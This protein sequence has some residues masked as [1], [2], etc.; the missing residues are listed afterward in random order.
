MDTNLPDVRAGQQLSATWLNKLRD[1]YLASRRIVQG[2][3]VF[4][5][6]GPDGVV[7]TVI[8]ESD[9]WAKITY[10]GTGPIYSWLE[11]IPA[12]SGTWA[13]GPTHGHASADPAIGSEYADPAYEANNGTVPVNTIV[14]C[15]RDK[16]AGR[17]TFLY[18]DC[19]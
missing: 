13:D 8:R 6:T 1:L 18:S 12:G 15:S 16:Q 14:R 17:V 19:D 4:A 3:G 11:Q 5:S 10:Q 2:P 9:W 7:Y